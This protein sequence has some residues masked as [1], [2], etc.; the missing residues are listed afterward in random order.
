MAS[1]FGCRSNGVLDDGVLIADLP[2]ILMMFPDIF[3]HGSRRLGY[4]TIRVKVL[5]FDMVAGPAG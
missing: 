3:R 2:E 1:K 5:G 4:L